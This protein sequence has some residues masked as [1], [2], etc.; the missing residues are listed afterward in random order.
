[1]DCIPAMI[2]RKANGQDRHR[3]TIAIEKNALLPMSQN[4]A[5]PRMCRLLTSTWFTRPLSR[6][7]MKLQV[8]TPA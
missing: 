5:L 7:S 4:G 1:M 6:C 3:A 2:I 8:M